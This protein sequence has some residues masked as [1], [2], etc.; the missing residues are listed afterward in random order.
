MFVEIFVCRKG[1]GGIGF[2]D[3]FSFNKALFTKQ[4]WKLITNPS[5]LLARVMKVKYY[6]RENFMNAGLGSQPSFT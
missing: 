3:L 4:G 1:D 6:L 5:S 2:R